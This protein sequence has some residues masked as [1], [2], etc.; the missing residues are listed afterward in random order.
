[1]KPSSVRWDRAVLKTIDIQDRLAV[2]K[3]AK[4]RKY[5]KR[6]LSGAKEWESQLER[7]FLDAIRIHEKTDI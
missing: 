6:R 3:D 2:E 1:M 7:E 5:L 4:K